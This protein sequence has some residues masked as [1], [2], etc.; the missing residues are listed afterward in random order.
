MALDLFHGPD[1]F[2]PSISLYFDLSWPNCNNHQLRESLVEKDF[3]LAAMS[4]ILFLCVFSIEKAICF[5]FRLS[6]H[7]LVDFLLA[8]A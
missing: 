2:L 7:T 8:L 1:D 3:V 5:S 4:G 6:S